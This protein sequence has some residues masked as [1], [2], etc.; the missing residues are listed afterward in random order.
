[1]QDYYSHIESWLAKDVWTLEEAAFLHAH[2]LPNANVNE[3]KQAQ[4]VVIERIRDELL[5]SHAQKKDDSPHTIKK[6]V[7][8]WIALIYDSGYSVP[9]VLTDF[10]KWKTGQDLSY[11]ANSKVR[12]K[13]IEWATMPCWS[14]TEALI[15]LSGGL[16][17]STLPAFSNS[18]LNF[19]LAERLKR[20]VLA[21]QI[22]Y[23]ESK[24]EH[25]FKPNSVIEW[26]KKQNVS[27]PTHLIDHFS[28]LLRKEPKARGRGRPN[29][30]SKYLELYNQ[31]LKGG[32]RA[33]EWKDEIDFL[34][35]ALKANLGLDKRSIKKS[36]TLTKF[37]EAQEILP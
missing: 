14:S 11:T 13:F 3:I 35:K 16:P 30:I 12:A 32:Q 18:E 36:I 17:R 6:P 20:A 24:E 7:T 33:A 9:H 26:A 22:E 25:Y 10:Y 15:L 23:I 19:T 1:M 27:I 8:D 5:T 29:I 34:Y 28:A 2:V 4:W 21:R 37:T 31:R